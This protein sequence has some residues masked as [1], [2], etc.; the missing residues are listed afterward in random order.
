MTHTQ[1][2]PTISSEKNISNIINEL[3]AVNTT[4]SNSPLVESL[5]AVFNLLGI[6]DNEQTVSED[7]TNQVIVTEIN[8]NESHRIIDS[9]IVNQ[10]NN[11]NF[12]LEVST[13]KVLSVVEFTETEKQVMKQIDG[14]TPTGEH[15]MQWL[16]K[17]ILTQKLI[18][19]DPQI[20]VHTVNDTIFIIT[21]DI[22]M[23]CV[24]EFPQA[25]VFA[26]TEKCPHGVICKKRLKNSNIINVQRM[27]IVFVHVWLKAQKAQKKFMVTYLMTQQCYF[28]TLFIIILI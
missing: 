18:I 27:A 10:V 19:S 26:K 17:A 3:D 23:R 28:L 6:N 5:D 15:F 2:I 8:Q 7:T 11:Q 1:D 13:E 20:L 12:I 21:P 4:N 24:G 14:I 9:P 22:F 16:K 25:Q